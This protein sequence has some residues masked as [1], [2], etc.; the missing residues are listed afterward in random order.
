MSN[1]DLDHNPPNRLRRQELA[2]NDDWIT[3][4]LSHAQVGY[5]ATRWDEQPFIT[6]TT[7]WYDPQRHA[8]YFHSAPVGRLRANV[9]RH[10][11]VC[12]AT[13][14]AGNLLP[15]NVA[16]E[17]S[18]QYE[19]VIAFG[20]LNLLQ[21]LDE[22]GRALYGLIEKY[23]PDMVP[24]HQY[25]PITDAELKQTAVY[26]MVIDAWSGKRNWPDQAEQSPDW[27]PLSG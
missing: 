22:K 4:F 1:Y 15:S 23:F 20:R 24:G 9:E 10:E 25:R 14:Q 19:S 17:F 16:L 18:I 2:C 13:G 8:I 21:E 7:F 11:Q 12:F 27:S 3:N 6:P 5:V 26:Q